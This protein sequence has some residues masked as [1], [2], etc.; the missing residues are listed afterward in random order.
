MLG[1]DGTIS[2]ADHAIA[3]ALRRNETRSLSLMSTPR[4]NSGTAQTNRP[5]ESGVEMRLVPKTGALQLGGPACATWAKVSDGPD[6]AEP[7]V[8]G[9]RRSECIRQRPLRHWHMV[10]RA[11]CQRG[12]NTGNKVQ[13]S[14]PGDTVARVLD[15][16]QCKHV[17]DVSRV[18]KL[19]DPPNLAREGIFP[20]QFGLKRAAMI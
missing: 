7:F 14:K 16:G 11:L 15:E 19:E 17:L 10:R 2:G 13:K 5:P 12:S 8:A 6:E 9:A 3:F 20:G 1:P 4:V 18:Q